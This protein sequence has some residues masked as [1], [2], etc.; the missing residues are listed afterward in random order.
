MRPLS[1]AELARMR[2]LQT[3][4]MQDECELLQ[5]INGE[6]DAYGV[7]TISYRV[8]A[9]TACGLSHSQTGSKAGFDEAG[10]RG[11]LDTQVATEDLELRLPKGTVIRNIDRVR[12]TKRFG[13]PVTPATYEII[14][15]PQ[16]GPSGLLARVQNVKE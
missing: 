14:G 13:Q 11:R 15:T 8:V 5:Q 4:A 1:P 16:T 10:G 12:I 3:A 6:P 7:P 2:A 9:T